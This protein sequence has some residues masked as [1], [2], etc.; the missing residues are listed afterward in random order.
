VQAL[1]D[2]TSRDPVASTEEGQHEEEEEEEEEGKRLNMN[3]LGTFPSHRSVLILS[4]LHL[5]CPC[6]L[7]RSGF[8]I[9]NLCAL[10]SATCPSVE[11]KALCYKPEGRGFDS[12]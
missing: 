12:R 2:E 7:L 8:P 4:Y 6:G 3:K 11:V 5:G 9:K 1:R 10:L